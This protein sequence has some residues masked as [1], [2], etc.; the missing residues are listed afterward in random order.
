M[1]QDAC[2]ALAMLAD[3]D[4]DEGAARRAALVQAGAPAAMVAAAHKAIRAGDAGALKNACAALSALAAG[5]GDEGAASRAALVQ[6]GAPAAL[7]AAA[8]EA[9]R[10]GEAGAWRPP[11][12]H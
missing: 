9:I 8:H 3:G 1:L 5:Y 2:G 10:A 11:A 4:G 12:R 6:A 7:V